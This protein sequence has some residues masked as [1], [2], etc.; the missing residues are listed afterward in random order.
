M[1]NV[2]ARDLDSAT[3][4]DLRLQ[5]QQLSEALE[6]RSQIARAQGILM[7]R[8]GLDPNAAIAL[9]RRLS[10]HT[11]VK[12]RDVAVRVV[13]GQRMDGVE[14]PRPRREP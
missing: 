14:P 10:S 6:T 4:G 12:V 2:T 5:V 9:L 11:N 8:Y 1:G 7:E 13:A 3:E